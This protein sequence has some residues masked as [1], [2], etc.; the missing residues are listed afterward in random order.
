MVRLRAVVGELGR[1]EM[2]ALHG[3][4]RP[5]DVAIAR[6]R[7]ALQETGN[8]LK[9]RIS[10]LHRQRPGC[11]EDCGDLTVGQSERRHAAGPRSG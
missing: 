3:A 11:G 1:I 10:V 2:P 7:N 4:N 5:R 8:V 9:E 6:I